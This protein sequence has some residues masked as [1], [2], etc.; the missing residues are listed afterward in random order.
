MGF[1]E[2]LG[3]PFLNFAHLG[4]LTCAGWARTAPK[5]D[6]NSGAKN[7][8]L[9]KATQI[10]E[11]MTASNQIP[12]PLLTQAQCVGVIPEM[13]KGG[14]IAGAEH[15][16]GVV[17][18]RS[19]QGW[20]APAFF[21]IS[22][23]SVGFQAGLEKSQIVLL[24]NQQG[25]QY[26]T[27]DNFQLGAEAVAAGPTSGTSGSV[28]WKAPILSYAKSKGAYAGINLA[29]STI[30]LDKDAIHEVYGSDTTTKQVLNGGV[31]TPPQAEQFVATVRKSA[32][33]G[34]VMLAHSHELEALEGRRTNRRS[35]F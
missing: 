33:P 19:G 24:M 21:S 12:D 1:S 2:D 4:L 29:G 20:S 15:G 32:Q 10:L 8:E 28:G 14:F 31:K 7:E 26:F 11:E 35:S 16:N 9:S 34:L 23:G 27:G 18:C 6:A 22:G 17:S 5:N 13:T 3:P 30:K 25:E